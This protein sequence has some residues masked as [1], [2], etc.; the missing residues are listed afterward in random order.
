MNKLCSK[1]EELQKLIEKQYNNGQ[2]KQVTKITIND[3][4]EGLL[5]EQDG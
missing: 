2:S 1:I 4:S 3:N 5:I